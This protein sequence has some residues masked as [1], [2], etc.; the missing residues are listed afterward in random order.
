[1]VE[2]NSVMSVD[3]WLNFWHFISVRAYAHTS[4]SDLRSRSMSWSWSAIF[5]RVIVLPECQFCQSTSFVS[6][7]AA[8][9]LPECQFFWR[10]SFT[11]AAV[12]PEHQFGSFPQHSLPVFQCVWRASF[13]GVP[14]LTELQF[15]QFQPRGYCSFIKAPVLPER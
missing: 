4:P 8:Q 15:F 10:A 1:M 13:V 9:V 7:A 2:S 14:V 6:F 11:T 3:Q 5:V 12:L